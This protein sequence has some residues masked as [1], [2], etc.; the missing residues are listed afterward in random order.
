[1]LATR[2]ALK[3]R[4][5]CT[6]QR[7]VRLKLAFLTP[8]KR[9]KSAFLLAL[10]CRMAVRETKIERQTRRGPRWPAVLWC[11]ISRSNRRGHDGAMEGGARGA[12]IA[13]G[14]SH[15]SNPGINSWSGE[16][17]KSCAGSLLSQNPS[18][19]VSNARP[20]KPRNSPA[21]VEVI[22]EKAF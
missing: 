11:S 18:N 14:Q 17:V 13:L 10:P 9:P 6:P 19:H 22:N 3:S 4:L 20:L 1:M 8:Q 15:W 5:W 7:K 16:R 2:C 12:F 21:G